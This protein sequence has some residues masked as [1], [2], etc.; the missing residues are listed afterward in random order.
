[1]TDKIAEIL[2]I[3][4]LDEFIGRTNIG[5]NNFWLLFADSEMSEDLRAA[6]PAYRRMEE[7]TPGF[8]KTLRTKMAAAQDK[9]RSEFPWEELYK[10][11]IIMAEL[12]HPDDEHVRKD[13]EIDRKYL[14]R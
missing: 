14:T 9:K 6:V 4:T 8:V 10:A 7:T 13:G 12:V 11:Y 1:M 3:S 2:E 5:D